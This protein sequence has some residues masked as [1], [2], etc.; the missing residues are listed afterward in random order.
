MDPPVKQTFLTPIELKKYGVRLVNRC[1]YF[2]DNNNNCPSMNSFA[3]YANVHRI[4]FLSERYIMCDDDVT[5]SKP[6]SKEMFFYGKKINIQ[7]T[8]KIKDLYPDKYIK[9]INGI[10]Y[11]NQIKSEI[12]LKDN[13][14]KLPN[15]YPQ[16]IDNIPKHCPYP[17]LK[18]KIIEFENEY[19]EWFKFISSHKTRFCFT[20]SD[21]ICRKEKGNLDGACY[22][23]DSIKAM[24]WY[25]RIKYNNL[26]VSNSKHKM[27]LYTVMYE[28]VTN[29]KLNHILENNNFNTISLN[30]TV[31]WKSDMLEIQ[32]QYKIYLERKKYVLNTLDSKFSNV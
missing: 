1:E 21:K 5:F 12:N 24:Y 14:V 31:F 22:H 23:E 15:K 26:F 7:S 4:P 28:D 17:F 27:L 20:D 16:I 13:L 2:I 19:K 6:M 25:L 11:I 10:K 30:D 18:S 9:K 32:S 3:I 29:K 8:F